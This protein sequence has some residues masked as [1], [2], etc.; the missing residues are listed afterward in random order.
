VSEL[1]QEESL[2]WDSEDTAL[3]VFLNISQLTKEVFLGGE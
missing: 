3:S 2:V 1:A